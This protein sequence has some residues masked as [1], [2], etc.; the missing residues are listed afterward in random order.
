[1]KRNTTNEKSNN[2]SLLE[3]LWLKYFNESLLAKGLITQEEYCKMNTRIIKRK[4][5]ASTPP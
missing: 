5:R 2:Q 4:G 1:M 3:Q